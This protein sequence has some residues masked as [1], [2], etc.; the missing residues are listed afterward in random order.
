[1]II[2][3]DDDLLSLHGQVKGVNIITVEKAIAKLK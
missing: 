1:M 3:G 2:S